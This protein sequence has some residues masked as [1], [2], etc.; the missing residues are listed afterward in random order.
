M[1][2]IV[3]LKAQYCGRMDDKEWDR[4]ASL[5][6]DDATMQ[7][8]PSAEAAVHGRNAIKSLVS[9]QLRGGHSLHEVRNAELS[10][11]SGAR[12]RVVWEMTDR[13]ETPRYTLRG[14]GFYEDEYVETAQGWKIA[15]VRLHRSAVDL[16]PRSPIMRAILWLHERGWLARI[17][18]GAG[19]ALADAL[20]VG[21]GEG[22]RP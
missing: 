13:V 14:R 18:P 6:V 19:R 3:D 21:L 11:L 4:W 16:Q 5:F 20:H 12:V 1:Q 7:F 8:G 2:A 15:R 9:R 10:E 22:Q 17:A